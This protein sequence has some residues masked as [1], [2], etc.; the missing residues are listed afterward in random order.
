MAD[1]ETKKLD[2]LQMKLNN[3]KLA[4]AEVQKAVSYIDQLEFKP[5]VSKSFKRPKDEG[6]ILMKDD[7]S[8]EAENINRNNNE[9]N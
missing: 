5:M 2:K 9:N 7:T 6:N 8:K 4:Q 1:D 3:E